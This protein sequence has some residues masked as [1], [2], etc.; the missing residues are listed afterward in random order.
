MCSDIVRFRR[1]QCSRRSSARSLWYCFDEVVVVHDRMRSLKAFTCVTCLSQVV[2]V[3]LKHRC[4]LLEVVA[5]YAL[6]QP[7]FLLGHVANVP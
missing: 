5:Q 7:S 1:V 4:L 2:V 3:F 6:L